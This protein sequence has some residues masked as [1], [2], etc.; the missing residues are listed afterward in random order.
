MNE[1][2]YLWRDFAANIKKEI[3]FLDYIIAY[4]YLL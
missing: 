3:L 2:N 4:S 1:D